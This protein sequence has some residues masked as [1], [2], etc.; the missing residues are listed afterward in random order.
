M[1]FNEFILLSE[2]LSPCFIEF[3]LDRKITYDK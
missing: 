3:E 2:I 1:K